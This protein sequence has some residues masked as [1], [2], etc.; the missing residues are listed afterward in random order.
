MP[1]LKNKIARAKALSAKPLKITVKKLEDESTDS[2]SSRSPPHE[3]RLKGRSS[4]QLPTSTPKGSTSCKNIMKNYSRALVKFALSK[5][6]IPYLNDMLV[7]KAADVQTFRQFIKERRARI[8]CIRSLKE[9]L[10]IEKGDSERLKDIK[11]AFQQIS[12]IFLKYFSVNWIFS[13]KVSDKLVHLKYRFKMLRR[14][15]NPAY[16]AYL[17]EISRIH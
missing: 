9:L 1:F 13:S 2:Q 5:L 14:I 16:F 3:T 12:E 4:Y 10:L 17:Q 8:N 7:S 15:R 6:A 11:T